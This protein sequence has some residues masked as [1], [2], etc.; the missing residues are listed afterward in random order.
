M[1]DI[2]V[3]N[4]AGFI[5]DLC[6]FYL[7]ISKS[8]QQK[9][10]QFK[11]GKNRDSYIITHAW[12][13]KILG[14]RLQC[15][16]LSIEFKTNR[17]GKPLLVGEN[18]LYFN[19]SHSENYALIAISEICPIGVDVE[20]SKSINFDEIVTRF[21]HPNE[22]KYFFSQPKDKRRLVFYSL[23]TKKEAFIK[24]IGKGLSINLDSFDA[25]TPQTGGNIFL[26]NIIFDDDY[27]AAIGWKHNVN[28]KLL[29]QKV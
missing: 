9:A 1:I 22:Q 15:D 8:E 6:A 17:Y 7:L 13:R 3:V 5:N 28:S 23:W 2:Y 20:Y 24:T 26:K 27:I 10:L 11:F 29:I 19:L 14:I 4:I 12:L 21:F 16:P 25:S 18:Q